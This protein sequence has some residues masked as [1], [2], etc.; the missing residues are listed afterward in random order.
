MTGSTARPRSQRCRRFLLILPIR[1]MTTGSAAIVQDDVCISLWKTDDRLISLNYS[2][3]SLF[4]YEYNEFYELIERQEITIPPH[5][6]NIINLSFMMRPQLK[7]SII[8]CHCTSNNRATD[9]VF[10]IDIDEKKAIY[11]GT[12]KLDEDLMVC[13]V[14]F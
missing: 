10:L 12:I 6:K 7:N 3:C 2:D 11:W 4:L 1:R 9:Y 5:Y 13:Y 8:Y 14:E